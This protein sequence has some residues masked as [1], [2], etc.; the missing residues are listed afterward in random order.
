MGVLG[1]PWVLDL[2]GVSGKGSESG[3]LLP[4]PT[5]N[6]GLLWE[7]R[8]VSGPAKDFVLE[9]EMANLLDLARPALGNGPAAAAAAPDDNVLMVSA[10]GGADGTWAVGH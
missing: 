6:W 3:R 9:F 7:P 4:S 10:C 1:L 2:G 8:S 5:P